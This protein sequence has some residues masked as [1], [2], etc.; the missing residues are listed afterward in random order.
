MLRK[1]R[2]FYQHGPNFLISYFI[3]PIMWF[4]N[5]HLI[6]GSKSPRRAHLLREAGFSFV[7]RTKDVEESYPDSLPPEEVA[8]FLAQKKALAMLEFLESEGDILLTADSIVL[9]DDE[10]FGKPTDREDAARILRRLSGNR[11]RVITGVCLRSSKKELL[12]AGESVVYFEALSEE[13]I[14]Y[15]IDHFQPYDKAGAYAIQEWIGLCKISK[16]EGTYA[17]IMG[18]PVDMVYDR[19][20]EF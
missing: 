18:L 11:H 10:I 2:E 16:I 8:T 20:K 7:I 14:T 4:S 5:K 17:N 12:F 6:L 1:A 3:L 9:L 13:E 15:Y 19:L